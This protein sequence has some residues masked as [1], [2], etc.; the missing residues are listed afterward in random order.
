MPVAQHLTRWARD[1]SPNTPLPS[2]LRLL[3]LSYHHH[4]MM[5]CSDLPL[6]SLSLLA[7]RSA[8]AAPRKQPQS[9]S[10]RQRHHKNA[11]RSTQDPSPSYSLPA[12]LLSLLGARHMDT[13]MEQQQKHLRGRC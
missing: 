4:P 11:H 12:S 2:F 13:D 10:Y 5:L 6:L 7:A 1:R 9:R 8:A 3:S